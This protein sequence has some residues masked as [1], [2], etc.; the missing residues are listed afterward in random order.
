MIRYPL[1]ILPTTST[2]R[3]TYEVQNSTVRPQVQDSVADAPQLPGD[4]VLV[5][6]R[7]GR[8]FRSPRQIIVAVG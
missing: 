3:G 7:S 5:S 6:R 1:G 4:I 2:Y 8:H